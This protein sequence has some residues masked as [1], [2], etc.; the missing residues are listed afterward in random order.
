MRYQ[1]R[2]LRGIFLL[3]ITMILL[4]CTA[5]AGKEENN[6]KVE[7]KDYRV[8]ITSDMHCTTLNEWYDVTVQDRMQLWVD[9]IIAEHEI[10]PFDLIIING[11]VSLDY[12]EGAGGGA[13]LTKGISETQFFMEN[14][15]SQLPEGVPVIVLPGNHEQY[16]EKEWQELTGNSRSETYILGNNLFIMP[17]SYGKH[18]NPTFNHSGYYTPFDVEYLQ[19]LV[20]QYP[21]HNVYIVSHSIDMIEQ[22]SQFGDFLEKNKNVIGL[23]SGHTH[24]A[25]NL[26]GKVY[27]GRVLAQTGN[28]GEAKAED[29]EN[30]FWGFRDLTITAEHASSKY[31]SVECDATID[32]QKLHFERKELHLIEYY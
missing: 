12:R 11:D 4:L 1:K 24:E 10:K 32:G 8:L 20:D 27:R 22:G 16:G 2:V 14:Y 19:E 5:C 30:N 17:D 9:A 25:Q 6:S 21:E 28:F 13:V 15:V 29:K 26:E 23:F 3:F 18:L 31:I 7:K